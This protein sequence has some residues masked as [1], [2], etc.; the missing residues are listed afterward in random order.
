MQD[1]SGAVYEGVFHALRPAG[2]DF[3]VLLRMAKAVA[4][5]A[6]VL[7][8]TVSAVTRYTAQSLDFQWAAGLA[9]YSASMAPT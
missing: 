1:K 4:P 6:A 9:A 5:A 8:R 2:A 3:D 7:P